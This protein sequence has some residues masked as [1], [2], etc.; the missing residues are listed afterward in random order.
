MIL[1]LLFPEGLI[2]A[3]DNPFAEEHS[4]LQVALRLGFKLIAHCSVGSVPQP[5]TE[6]ADLWVLKQ[7]FRFGGESSIFGVPEI[8]PA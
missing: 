6:P 7:M 2:W 5:Q 3:P 8:L 4:H 1:L